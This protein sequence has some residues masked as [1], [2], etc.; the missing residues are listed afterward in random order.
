MEMLLQVPKVEQVFMKV[1]YS[2]MASWVS[3][4]VTS[5]VVGAY[6]PQS[7]GNP[8]DVQRSQEIH[9]EQRDARSTPLIAP[10]RR[11]DKGA[12]DDASECA[13]E[14]SEEALKRHSRHRTLKENSKEW[15]LDNPDYD[16]SALRRELGS[17]AFPIVSSYCCAAIAFFVPTIEGNQ[18]V[19]SLALE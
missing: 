1:N 5:F 2:A 8:K 16:T 18:A 13:L 3:L 6:T 9:R 15:H 4:D 10:S 11:C 12:P 19:T 14:G 17:H 7:G